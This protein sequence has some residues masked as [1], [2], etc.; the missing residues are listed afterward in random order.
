MSCINEWLVHLEFSHLSRKLSSVA[1]L[2][3]YLAVVNPLLGQ[4]FVTKTL[5]CL[6]IPLNTMLPGA[7]SRTLLL[8]FCVGKHSQ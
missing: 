2:S 4:L 3:D 6:F 1:M 7:C 8:F 5:C